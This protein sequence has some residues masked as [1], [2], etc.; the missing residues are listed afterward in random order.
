MT[1]ILKILQSWVGPTFVKS[2]MEARDYCLHRTY[3]NCINDFCAGYSNIESI[4]E[5]FDEVSREFISSAGLKFDRGIRR[6]NPGFYKSKILEHYKSRIDAGDL[7]GVGPF[8]VHPCVSAYKAEWESS[9]GHMLRSRLE[10]ETGK[11]KYVEF[12]L[13]GLDASNWTGA[14][15]DA[16]NIAREMAA[17][18]GFIRQKVNWP[19][20]R[21]IEEVFL[22]ESSSG[23]IFYFYLDKA[24]SGGK[25]FPTLPINFFVGFGDP[26]FSSDFYLAD[27]RN[28]VPGAECYFQYIYD[29]EAGVLGLKAG[30]EIFSVFSK[31]FSP[32]P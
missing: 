30:L 20:Y 27:L 9:N 15:S 25:S 3:I 21:E 12:K 4:S 7:P 31:S 16:E 1:S 13:K 26:D 10:E 5:Y 19:Q 8:S 6:E 29:G 28:V 18:F 17:D 14:T 23:L 2:E 32:H 11:R 24:S 22:V